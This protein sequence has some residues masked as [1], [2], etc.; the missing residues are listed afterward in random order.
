MLLA[1]ILQGLFMFDF[2]LSLALLFMVFAFIHSHKYFA[3]KPLK[4]PVPK[5][6]V[7]Y[8]L[9]TV[10][11]VLPIW[12]L[13]AWYPIRE[14]RLAK[15]G[16]DAFA[17]GQDEE[18]IR[19]FE[20]AL[21]YDTYGNI[22]AR[23]SV[24]EYAFEFLKVGGKRDP[25][26]LNRLIDYAIKKMNENI[27]E[28]PMDVKWYMYV[29]ELNNLAA[30]LLADSKLEYARVAEDSFL[31][32]RHL[33]PGRPNIY[34]EIAQARKV[35]GNE[36]G[37]WESID[38]GIA[39]LP[40]S[41]MLHNFALIF[42]IETGNRARE[43]EEYDYVFSK[44]IPDYRNITEAYYKVSR[45]ADAAHVHRL[46]IDR[47]E[48]SLHVIYSEE[49]RAQLYKDLAVLEAKAGNREAARDAAIR[50]GKAF[51]QFQGEVEAFI[52]SLGL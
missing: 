26:S 2:L 8:R 5:R 15:L 45:F 51:P 43:A 18:A 11:I 49:E 13:W 36:N 25:A 32:A 9:V 39:I 19:L 44:D 28:H 31:K 34:A 52:K 38:E 24:A 30:V 23:R 21:S 33:S 29:G 3:G 22:D 27:L 17:V 10:I 40:D 7:L 4:S 50:F 14:N 42:A 35:Q 48:R 20:E 37:L 12:I 1:H 47:K 41:K 46:F 6:L 16:Y